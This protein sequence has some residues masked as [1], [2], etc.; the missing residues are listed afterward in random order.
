MSTLKTAN[1]QSPDLNSPSI[2]ING[3]TGVVTMPFNASPSPYTV[4][5][6]GN[7]A[8]S[9]FVTISSVSQD[10]NTLKI[11]VKNATGANFYGG[12]LKMRLGNGG[13]ATTHN[14]FRSH[15]SS[16]SVSGRNPFDVMYNE[17]YP[18]V[19]IATIQNYTDDNSDANYNY[20]RPGSFYMSSGAAVSSLQQIDTEIGS[21]YLTTQLSYIELSYSSYVQFTGG[22]YTVYGINLP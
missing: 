21:V 6:T 20:N 14:W 3:T 17:T 18:V 10:Y 13:G 11:V 5:A 16:T 2:V 12:V 9:A 15:Q 8:G 22:T 7:L 1:V 19:A 4:L